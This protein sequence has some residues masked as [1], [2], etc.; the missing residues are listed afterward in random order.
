MRL[1]LTAKTLKGKNF[2]HN[3]CMGIPEVEVLEEREFVSCLDGH[4]GFL[5]A[6][7][8]NRSVMRW[9]RK[10]NDANFEI[11]LI[12]RVLTTR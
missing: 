8:A 5:V 1:R 9:I 6:P 12:V 10:F 3:A 4:V 11:E 2:I 7:I